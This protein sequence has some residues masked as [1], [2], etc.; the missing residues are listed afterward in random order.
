MPRTEITYVLG[1]AMHLLLSAGQRAL[2]DLSEDVLGLGL[3]RPTFL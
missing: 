3:G 1:R 2:Q